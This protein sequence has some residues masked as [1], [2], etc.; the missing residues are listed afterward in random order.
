MVTNAQMLTSEEGLWFAEEQ[1]AESSKKYRR[2][3][4]CGDNWTRRQQWWQR[5][6]CNLNE[7]FRGSLSSKIKQIYRNLQVL[8]AFPRM[9]L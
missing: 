1:E 9:E 3:S 6:E 8:L 5:D 7:L 4:Q 2:R